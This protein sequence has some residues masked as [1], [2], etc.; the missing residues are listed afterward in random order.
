MHVQGKASFV[1]DSV[2]LSSQDG[3]V[4]VCI[5]SHPGPVLCSPFLAIPSVMED[6]SDEDGDDDDDD[7]QVASTAEEEG[8]QIEGAPANTP[9]G[10]EEGGGGGIGADTEEKEEE[11]EVLE[12]P[13]IVGSAEGGRRDVIFCC[14]CCCRHRCRCQ[15]LLAHL[16]F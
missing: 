2:T 9:C 15:C 14:C 13:P 4:R 11:E 3:N 16:A 12:T 7:E 5:G 8:T 1:K 10:E 6:E